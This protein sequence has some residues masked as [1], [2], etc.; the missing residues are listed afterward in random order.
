MS[1]KELNINITV[2]DHVQT[3][4]NTKIDV[5]LTKNAA[6]DD[7]SEIFNRINNDHAN[8]GQTLSRND[9]VAVEITF[10][11]KT[12][13][14]LALGENIGAMKN[15]L[16]MLKDPMTTSYSHLDSFRDTYTYQN[17]I[18]LSFGW[19][20]REGADFRDLSQF[21]NKFSQSGVSH[22]ELSVEVNQR[23]PQSNADVDEP[24]LTG[25]LSFAGK[26]LEEQ[27]NTFLKELNTTER[28]MKYISLFMNGNVDLKFHS[29]DFAIDHEIL[30]WPPGLPRIYGFV[31][32]KQLMVPQMA[33]IFG[34]VGSD[35]QLGQLIEDAY[36]KVFDSISG[37]SELKVA[38][39][40]IV[41]KFK[42]DGFEIFNGFLPEASLVKELSTANLQD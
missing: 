29:L 31:A 27:F 26:A 28:G 36:T 4:F 40:G 35:P 37:F 8:N 24:K 12:N 7:F 13:D 14:V 2:G 6:S 25:K 10:N 9:D 38:Y 41:L 17:K 34:Q 1:H 19:Q 18:R 20:H 39:K 23:F 15:Y 32:L 30:P 3:T 5:T 21:A 11:T 33:A 16:N 22:L 42:F